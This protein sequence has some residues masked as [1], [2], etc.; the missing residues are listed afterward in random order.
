MDHWQQVAY[1]IDP[2]QNIP[3]AD[4]VGLNIDAKVGLVCLAAA[5]IVFVFGG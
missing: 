4:E 5:V 3:F 2:W 1:R